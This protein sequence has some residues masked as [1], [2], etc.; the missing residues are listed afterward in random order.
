MPTV[1]IDPGH[2]GM[3]P[4]AVYK[5][6]QE[7]DDNLRLALAVGAGGETS[8][9]KGRVGP[10]A[11][12]DRPRS[13]EAGG[14]GEPRRGHRS[15]EAKP[16]PKQG[17]PKGGRSA[18]RAGQGQG[19]SE[20]ARRATKEP[21]QAPSGRAG[22]QGPRGGPGDRAKRGRA[23]APDRGAKRRRARR[24]EAT[25]RGGR[26]PGARGGAE[27]PK[28]EGEPPEGRQRG[29]KRPP[30]SRAQPQRVRGGRAPRGPGGPRPQQKG[31]RA[32]GR[33]PRGTARAAPLWGRAKRRGAAAPQASRGE[34]PQGERASASVSRRSGGA[35]PLQLLDTRTL[36]RH[37]PGERYVPNRSLVFRRRVANCP[38]PLL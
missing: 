17:R 38:R 21:A 8:G 18:A 6:R 5:G 29:T 22:G 23:Q 13:R 26:G 7:K 28:S 14:P 24:P 37:R 30:S 9:P 31:P 20:R 19:A 11:G 12:A 34:P 36:F 4:G 16:E 33:C 15:P 2:G 35:K 32:P 27:W 10:G 1:I 25:P 3:D